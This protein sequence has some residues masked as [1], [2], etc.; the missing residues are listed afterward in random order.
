M[1]SADQSLMNYLSNDWGSAQADTAYQGGEAQRR[2]MR[3]YTQYDLPDLVNSEAAKGTYY[4]GGARQR[5]DRLR[6]AANEGYG[7]IQYQMD[8]TIADLAR[9]RSLAGMGILL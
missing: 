2:L 5:A 7:D 8:N 6:T 1:A 4:S 3:N 9:K